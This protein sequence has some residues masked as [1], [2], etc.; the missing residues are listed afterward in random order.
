MNITERIAGRVQSRV[1]D[2]LES[3]WVSPAY[4]GWL[5]GGLAIF[6]F[7]AATN[8]MAGWLYA[9]SGVSLALLG[10]AAVMPVRTLRQITVRRRPV[11]PVSVG[12]QLTVE[13]EIE[14]PTPQPK[15]LLQIRDV[16]PYVLGKPA[17][18]TIESIPPQGVYLWVYYQEASRR[19]IYRW[20][21]IQLRTGTPLGLFWC[22]RS[23][24]AKATAFVY[25]AVLPIKNCPLVDEIG[26]QD[27]PLLHSDRRSQMAT[28]G[29]TRT[30]RP[31]RFGD[32]TRLI[33]W[34][35]SARYGEFRVRELEVSTGGKEIIISLDSAWMWR[36]EDFE[37]AVTAAASLYFYAS[38]TQL[39]AQLWTAGTGL[40]H[41]H[42]VVLETLAGTG[43][44]ED[45]QSGGPPELPL[46]WL[47]Q[48]PVSL[49]SLP[50]GS[51]WVLWAPADPVQEGAKMPVN[52]DKPGIEIQPDKPLQLQLQSPF[53]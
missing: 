21:E 11:E 3:H 40:V 10:I 33:H 9:I 38:R 42:K 41:G 19:G 32:P 5:L 44:G 45:A 7:A 20:D 47:T 36:P 22:R 35:S 30:L 12:D 23:Q 34:R 16:L 37:Q 50:P 46:I 13:I 8:T 24:Y 2:W 39:S 43:F 17:A 27:S 18:S 28:E 31:Y 15:T 25:P 29:I 52:R 49:N 1:A 51:R 48:N 4:A 14:N 53:R 6:F 26:L